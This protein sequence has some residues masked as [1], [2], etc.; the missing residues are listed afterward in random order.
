MLGSC[1]ATDGLDRF[2][3][4]IERFWLSFL[5]VEHGKIFSLLKTKKTP[6]ILEWFLTDFLTEIHDPGFCPNI[7]DLN[8]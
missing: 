7:P 3:D 5:S 1:R 6:L 2:E 4:Q 8:W